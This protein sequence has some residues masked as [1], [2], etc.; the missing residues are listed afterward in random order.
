MAMLYIADS[1]RFGIG[2]NVN[3]EQAATWFRRAM[4]AGSTSAAYKLGCLNS[5]LGNN[6]E[7][8]G[9][10]LYAASKDFTP[11]LARLGYMYA[12]G[13]G[14]EPNPEK[15]REFLERAYGRGHLYAQKVLSGLLIRQNFGISQKIRGLIIA[16]TIPTRIV[17]IAYRHS[18]LSDDASSMDFMDEELH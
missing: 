11:A 4:A 13:V 18:K 1:Y 10:L 6:E 12:K 17:R 2:T 3:L 9:N 16:I 8:E 14:V 5:D 15:A 7:A